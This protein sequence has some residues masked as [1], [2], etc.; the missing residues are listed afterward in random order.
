MM[1]SNWNIFVFGICFIICVVAI[2]KELRRANKKH[3]G[4]RVTAVIIAVASLACIALPISY[5]T[6]I[7]NSNQSEA[8]LLTDGF[9]ADNLSVYKDSRLFTLDN[10]IKKRYPNAVLL[11]ELDHLG[12]DSGITQLHILGDGL[13]EYQLSQL[14]HLFINF[15]PEQFKQGISAVNWNARLKTGDELLVQGTYKNTSANKVKLLLEGLNTSL[16]SAF[17]KPGTTSTFELKNISKVSGRVVYR[18]LTIMGNDTANYGSIPFQVDSVAPL[19]VLTLASSPDFES[20]FLK[21]WLS[22]KGYAVALRSTISKDKFRTEFI[23]MPVVPLEYISIPMLSKFDLLI[24]D[25]SALKTLPPQ[26]LAA[27]KTAVSQNGFGVIIKADSTSGNSWLQSSFP[28]TI[29]QSKDTLA[30]PILLQQ[31][32]QPLAAL[33]AGQSYIKFQQGTQ[34]LARN[35]HGHVLAAAALTGNGKMVYTTINN[36]FSWALAGNK[37]DYGRFWSALIQQAAR[38]TPAVQ[39]WDITTTI[40]SISSPVDLQLH[41]T[42]ADIATTNGATLPPAQNTLLPFQY[43]YQYRPES[44]GWQFIK[45]GNTSAWWYVYADNEWQSLRQLKKQADTKNHVAGNAGRPDVTKQI[46]KKATIFVSKIYPYILLLLACTFLW[47]EA[48][49]AQTATT[50]RKGQLVK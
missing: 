42:G 33:A 10:N 23:N 9:N 31:N 27:L 37:N 34:A 1:Q 4:W 18:L 13:S 43:H 26:N 39:Q 44:A 7:T 6:N 49:I 32:T 20:R 11:D 36:T 50:S 15:H 21:N 30:S 45:A 22:E 40:P 2:W 41:A 25:L 16:D 24:G 28:T 48:K 29:S 38:K 14:N 47:A 19:K 3:L 46:Q 12:V 5:Q 35:T 17:V 8:V